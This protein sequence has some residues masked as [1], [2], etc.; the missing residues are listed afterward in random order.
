MVLS[1]SLVISR[2]RSAALGLG[3]VAAASLQALPALAAP[4]P[5]TAQL[6]A[7]VDR[8]IAAI[9]AGSGSGIAA[10]YV[11]AP[12]IVDEFAPFHWS[13]S[14]AALQWFNGFS[15]VARES[16]LSHIAVVHHKPS[17]IAVDGRHAWIVVPT[18]YHYQVAGKAQVESA[19]WTF[20]LASSAGAWKIESSTWAKTSGAP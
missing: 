4:A 16:A 7:P 1:T 10:A 2:F 13:G 3:L 8:L 17:Y 9:D 19:A 12:S 6:L 5:T 18:D 14:G 15:A 20:V 11:A